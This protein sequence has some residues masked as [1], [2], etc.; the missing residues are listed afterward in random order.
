MLTILTLLALG[1]PV[2]CWVLLVRDPLIGSVVA[3][4]L[5]TSAAG[6]AS[7]AAGWVTISR[8]RLDLL[9]TYPLVAA[10]ILGIGL[11]LQR[12]RPATAAVAGADSQRRVAGHVLLTVYIGL[13]VLVGI[14]AATYFVNDGP[15]VP[16]A[17]ELLPLPADLA[18]TD[19]REIGCGSAECDRVMII[20]SRTGGSSTDVVQRLREHLV[21]ARGWHL[22]AD[23][24]ACR[25]RGWIVDRTSLCLSISVNQQQE[26]HVN[27]AGRKEAPAAT[28]AP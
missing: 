10:V 11:G 20:S 22:D 18:V 27:L 4:V 6:Y 15:F 9:V 7:L 1:V 14:P 3:A 5:L 8:G 2:V 23:D 26:V 12:H 25:P 17:S 21:R 19:N 28:S 16:S 24:S 13:G